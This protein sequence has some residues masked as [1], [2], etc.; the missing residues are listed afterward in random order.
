MAFEPKITFCYHNCTTVKITDTTD[1]YNVDSNA[2]GW[3]T[4][5]PAASDITLAE[6]IID[7]TTYTVTD[8]LPGEV[9]GPFEIDLGEITLA[10]GFHDISYKVYYTEGEG[11]EAVATNTLYELREFVTC[12]TRCCIDKMWLRVA[13]SHCNCDKGDLMNKAIEA[14]ALLKA[15]QTA[16]AACGNETQATN[17]LESVQ[18]ICAFEECN[19][20]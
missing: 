10:D 17:I 11:A 3:N 14:E 8:K 20:N 2:T 13:D 16:A 12:A 18:G 6:V 4:P 15:A 19:C 1:V 7:G 9:S 5:N